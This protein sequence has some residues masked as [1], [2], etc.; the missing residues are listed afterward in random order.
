MHVSH[1]DLARQFPGKA[2]RIEILRL[3][4][5]RFRELCETYRELDRAIHRRATDAVP[6]DRQTVETLRRTRSI[7]REAIAASLA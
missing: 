4:D 7:L 3:E 1:D 6:T 2:D 5:R